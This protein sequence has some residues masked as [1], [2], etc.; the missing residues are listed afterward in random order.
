MASYEED[1]RRFL[2]HLTGFHESL[3][4]ELTQETFF[5]AYLALP[6]FRGE[7]ALKSWL[8]Q[9]AKNTYFSFLRRQ[10]AECRLDPGAAE[11]V[12]ANP[13]DEPAARA[14]RRETRERILNAVR[15]FEPKYRDV[16]LYRLFSDLPYAQIARLLSLSE[17]SCKVLFF[18]GKQK[19]LQQLKEDSYGNV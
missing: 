5:R 17:S 6:R 8:F 16:M 18:R 2:L 9:I 10:K 1:V 15:S 4:E 12:T 13:D 7:C 3:A 19:L 11:S 14:E